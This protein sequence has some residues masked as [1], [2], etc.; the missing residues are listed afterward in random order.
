MSREDMK[1]YR[2][3][4]KYIEKAIHELPRPIHTQFTHRKNGKI[5]LQIKFKTFS[6]DTM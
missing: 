5:L 1:K 6:N 2:E 3:R 4:K